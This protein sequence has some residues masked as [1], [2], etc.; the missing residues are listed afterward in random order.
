MLLAEICNNAEDMHSDQPQLDTVL[1][2]N[3][4]LK[5]VIITINSSLDY[6]HQKLLLKATH[7][8]SAAHKLLYIITPHQKLKHI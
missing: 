4:A 3:L 5:D 2:P 7:V 6:Y 8:A 1:T